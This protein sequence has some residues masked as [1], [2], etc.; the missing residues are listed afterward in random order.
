MI[1]AIDGTAS[2][3]K[4]SASIEL[5]KRLNIPLLPTG[6]V[7]RAITFKALNEN[8]APD[9]SS[10]LLKMIERTEVDSVY[11]NKE[12]SIYLDRFPVSYE[13][14]KSQVVSENVARYSCIP[15]VREFVRKIQ[16]QQAKKYADI[17]VEGRDI[18]SVVF[19]NADIKFFVDADLET[20]AKRRQKEYLLKGENLSL[21]KVKEI[22]N[23]RDEE[24][25][26]REIS[27][28]IMTSDSILIDTSN[29]TILG[30]VDEMI[31]KIN[32]KRNKTK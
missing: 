24:D 14:L 8:I 18:G 27:P 16:K 4:T 26:H 6:L 5:S 15:F 19:P 7:Y 21:E 3:G 25:R 12:V 32:Q 22:I 9:N 20:R 31:Q 29:M 13:E 30:V 28:L 23:T 2:S 11:M 1:I 17:I 10:D